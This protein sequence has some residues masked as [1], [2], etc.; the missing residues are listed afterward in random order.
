MTLQQFKDK[1]LR[2]KRL[3]RPLQAV[4]TLDMRS[5]WLKKYYTYFSTS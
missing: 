2:E 1:L 5:Y 3:F 4:L